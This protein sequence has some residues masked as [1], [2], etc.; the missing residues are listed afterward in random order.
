MVTETWKR[1]SGIEKKDVENSIG[2]EDMSTVGVDQTLTIPVQRDETEQVKFNHSDNSG[3][4]YLHSLI[5]FYKDRIDF[6]K[7]EKSQ[8]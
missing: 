1:K 7:K 3:T 4:N 5:D 8:E 6:M 2:L